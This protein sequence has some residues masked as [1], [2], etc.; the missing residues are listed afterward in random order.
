MM[1]FGER[2]AR[3]QGG[4]AP[5]EGG[6]AGQLIT[7]R[8]RQA[9]RQPELGGAGERRDAIHF[10]WAKIAAAVAAHVAPALDAETTIS[11]QRQFPGQFVEG[12]SP[13]YYGSKS[14]PTS[15]YWTGQ[16]APLALDAASWKARGKAKWVVIGIQV[17][18]AAVASNSENTR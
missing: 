2:R 18:Y 17:A 5:R 6:F 9:G 14:V 4:R 7:P 15:A 1:R 8:I 16:I 3:T 11:R 13:L 10:D 12:T